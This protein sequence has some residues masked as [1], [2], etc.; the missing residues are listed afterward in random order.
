MKNN[1][2]LPEIAE[3]TI[4]ID[5]S[6]C[7]ETMETINKLIEVTASF[8]T[9]KA[10]FNDIFENCAVALGCVNHEYIDVEVDRHVDV[11]VSRIFEAIQ[12]I[13]EN[14]IVFAGQMENRKYYEAFR[15]EEVS[16]SFD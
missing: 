15:K 7:P 8:Y 12:T 11:C 13:I 14:E 4:Q 16:E 9:T 6:L 2:S 10:S 3:T 1:N 5:S